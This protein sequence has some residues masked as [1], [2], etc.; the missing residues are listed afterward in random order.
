MKKPVKKIEKKPGHTEIMC[1]VDESGSMST[2]RDDVI[3]SINE[4]A[5]KQADDKNGTAN[6]T[7]VK[8]N[9]SP[10]TVYESKPVADVP[11]LT[12]ETYNPSGG[13]ALLDAVAR[14]VELADDRCKASGDSKAKVV[15]VVM[16]DGQEN[17]SVKTTREQLKALLENR[18]KERGWAVTFLGANI[19]SFAD[20]ASLGIA[21][22]AAMNYA[23][24][25][26]GVKAMMCSVGDSVSR[27]RSGE[28]ATLN[29]TVADRTN[30]MDSK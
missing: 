2:L 12:H 18:Q 9:T 5:K 14:A 21:K 15:I 1:V 11:K 27:L 28:D 13:T 10:T 29:Y 20:A 16:T 24:T 6:L 7:L 26:G 19:D 4:F 30:A 22:N 17:S 8:F 25:R 3:G 23:P